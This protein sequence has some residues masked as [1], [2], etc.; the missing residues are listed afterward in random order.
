MDTGGVVVPDSSAWI[1]YLRDLDLPVTSVLQGLLAE[2]VAIA[3]TEQVVLEVLA[4]ARSPR[5]LRE[6]RKELLS[7]PVLE[8]RGLADFES[9]AALYRACRRNGET[10]RKM[11][12]CLIAVPVI[13]EDAEILHNDADFDAIAR[14]SDLR[15]YRGG[16]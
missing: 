1:A 15:I 2:K 12:D 10:I 7:F 6:L 4:G 11:S 3:T 14:H 8:L 5:N 16:N 9:A 13:R